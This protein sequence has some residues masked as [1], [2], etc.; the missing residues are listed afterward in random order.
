[1]Q[2]LSWALTKTVITENRASKVNFSGI[3]GLQIKE[4]A[5]W[6]DLKLNSG[7]EFLIWFC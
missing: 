2:E 7:E 4:Y 6:D 5:G 1:M 3:I